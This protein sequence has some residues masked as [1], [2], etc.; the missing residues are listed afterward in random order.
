MNQFRIAGGAL[1]ISRAREHRITG[2]GEV[3]CYKAERSVGYGADNAR[4]RGR[5]KKFH[6]DYRAGYIGSRCAEEHRLTG[7]KYSTVCRAKDGDSRRQIRGLTD[8]NQA[9]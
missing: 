1:V 2:G 5:L 8:S 3:G 4:H 9:V 7:G 6:G